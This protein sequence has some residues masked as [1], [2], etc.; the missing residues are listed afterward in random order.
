FGHTPEEVEAA[1]NRGTP[2]LVRVRLT[3][4]DRKAFAQ[5][6][7]LSP[8]ISQSAVEVAKADAELITPTLLD[9]LVVPESAGFE[10]ALRMASNVAF[11]RA[12]M[13]KLPQQEQAKLVDAHGVL[14]QEG[15]KRIT[16]AVFAATFPGESGLR[17]AD[18]FFE[19]TDIN[20]KNVLNGVLGALGPLART[21]AQ[22]PEY[23]IGEDLA[24]AVMA[25]S[26][27]RARGM[28]VE[29]W[30]NQGRLFERELTG[31]QEDVLRSI[32]SRGRSGKRI[33]ELLR[34]YARLALNQPPSEQIS[35]I[36]DGG[37]SA[38]E[39]W[40]M[41]DRNTGAQAVMLQLQQ[42][43][44]R[45]VTH[46][47]LNGAALSDCALE[48]PAHMERDKLESCVLQVKESLPS[49]CFGTEGDLNRSKSG[50]AACPNPYAVCRAALS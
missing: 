18:S 5:E 42:T 1:A 34:E 19:A 50:T 45:D 10:Q 39:L 29:D 13:A 14:N 31:F 32:D 9:S 21:E 6:A 33:G 4:V 2:I 17:L 46:W 25:F 28:S 40:A 3:E 44:I 49:R 12:F 47:S 48:A 38:E 23:S 22:R 24:K 41:A 36:E 27:I 20:V 15:V 37:V 7:N 26:N 8:S 16:M 30:I 43:G 11:V 35:L